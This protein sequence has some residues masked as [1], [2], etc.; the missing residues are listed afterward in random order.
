MST[1]FNLY[2][3]FGHQITTRNS[4]TRLFDALSSNSSKEIILDFS[5]IEFISRSCADEYL[6]RKSKDLKKKFIEQNV[7]REVLQM[8]KLAM[9]QYRQDVG[10]TQIEN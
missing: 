2:S 9:L 6:K 5:K 10:L 7:N 8:F 3:I 1:K 4:I